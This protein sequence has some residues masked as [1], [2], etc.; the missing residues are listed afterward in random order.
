MGIIFWAGFLHWV[1]TV[2]DTKEGEIG[3][4]IKQCIQKLLDIVKH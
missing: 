3:G 1:R 4:G 2:K